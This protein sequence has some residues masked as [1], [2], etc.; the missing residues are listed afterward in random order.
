MK[1]VKPL[2][3]AAVVAAT[4]SGASAATAA[5]AQAVRPDTATS[6]FLA[7]LNGQKGPASKH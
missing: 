1:I 2:L 6:A 5:S 4:W 3:I 7:V